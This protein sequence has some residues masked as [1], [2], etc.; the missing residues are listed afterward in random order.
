DLPRFHL[1]QRCQHRHAGRAGADRDRAAPRCAGGDPAP[2]GRR[3]AHRLM[4]LRPDRL[5]RQ[6]AAE[7]LRPVYLIAG[8][9]PLLVQ[10]LA[11]AVRARARA[12]GFG[13]REVLDV[14]PGFDWNRLSQGL[15]SLS[16]FASRRLFELRLPSGKPGKDGSE[17][18][19]E[20]CERPPPDRSE[21]HTSELQ[22]REKLVCRLLL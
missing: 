22:S 7:P 18:L 4:E 20:F 14:E 15:A 17:A 3:P 5:E 10:E 16:L 21:E 13:E 1:R 11:D 8:S 12:E 19:R 2:P 9:E 6:L